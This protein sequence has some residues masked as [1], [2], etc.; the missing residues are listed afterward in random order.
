MDWQQTRWIDPCYSVW[1]WVWGFSDYH[2]A[3]SRDL[4]RRITCELSLKL[5]DEG[6]MRANANAA[7]AAYEARAAERRKAQ[8]CCARRG[9]P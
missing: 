2:I 9:C 6:V 8:V 5:G 4:S 3:K 1:V 7:V